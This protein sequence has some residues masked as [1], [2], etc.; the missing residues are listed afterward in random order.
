MPSEL[1]LSHEQAAAAKPANDAAEKRVRDAGHGCKNRSGADGEVADLEALGN[2]K[3][4][5][6]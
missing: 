1:E 6:G 5:L 4:S 3:F 2:H